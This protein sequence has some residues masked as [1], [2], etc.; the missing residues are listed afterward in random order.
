MSFDL[1]LLD[2]LVTNGWLRRARHPEAD[3]WIYN[4]TERTQYENHWTPETLAC[5]GLILDEAG[6]VVARPFPK[7][8]NHGTPQ[9]GPIPYGP[10]VA[11]EKVDGSLGIVYDLDGEQ[12]IATRGSFT[13]EQ[14]IEGTKM[15]RE[16]R[17]EPTPDHTT[18]FEIVYP[19]NRIV[20]DYGDRRELVLLG[21]IEKATGRGRAFLPM[22]SGRAVSHYRGD[23]IDALLNWADQSNREGF[24]LTWPEVGHRRKIKFDE[25]VR[26]H[27]VVTGINA[28]SV[29]ESM[30]DGDD[31]DGLLQ[32]VPD[33]IFDWVTKTRAAL[34]AAFND[35]A[36][37]ALVV[38][39]AMPD[40]ATTRGQV[41][42]Y[43]KASD[44]NLAVL[45]RMLD[46]K[47]YDDLIWK[48]IKPAAGVFPGT[49]ARQEGAG[50]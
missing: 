37:R 39:N 8:F 42:E 35:E 7:F 21:S 12:Y 15:L 17:L 9:A 3:L 24:V 5:R 14:A 48:A 45:F 34:L 46:G 30:R 6:E 33:E 23:D 13:S 16:G 1:E 31:L 41:A 27:R 22:W 2:D 28:R 10:C 25:Y 19:E 40:S 11:T 47:P 50:R 26:L 36:D 38:W 44:A 43:F 20:V 18:L 49:T 32:G 29:W 4:Y